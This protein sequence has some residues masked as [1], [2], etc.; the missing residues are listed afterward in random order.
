[1][2]PSARVLLLLVKKLTV[3]G[4]IEYTHG[5]STAARPPPSAARNSHSS[6][7]VSFSFTLPL[8][9]G[10]LLCGVV[11]VAATL[12]VVVS[13]FTVPSFFVVFSLVA[14]SVVAT[15]S[16]FA[17]SAVPPASV[18]VIEK[19]LSVGG[20]HCLSSHIWYVSLPG[21]LCV[22][23]YCSLLNVVNFVFEHVDFTFGSYYIFTD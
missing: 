6:D 11:P 23:F 17:V 3:I 19:V 10:V 13:A 18:I 1:M 14:E 16:A 2:I 7:F 12:A 15:S 22:S 21:D 5:V 9:S 8:G 4:I 20:R